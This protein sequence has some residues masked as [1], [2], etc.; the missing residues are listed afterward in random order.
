MSD[1]A[2]RIAELS[3]RKREL[4]LKHLAKKETEVSQ[5]IVAKRRAFD[6]A[7]LSFAQYRLWFIEKL[8]PGTPALNIPIGVRLT[9][10]LN[11]AAIEWGLNE[12]LKRHD[13]LR[14]TFDERDGQAVQVIK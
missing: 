13:V 7:P 11:V 9:G 1:T 10:Q 14:A 3:P 4:L 6:S 12:V 2:R 5:A 8:R